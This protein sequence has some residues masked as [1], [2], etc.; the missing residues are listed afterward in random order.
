MNNGLRLQKIKYNII[1]ELNKQEFVKTPA[2]VILLF[3]QYIVLNCFFIS[4][5]PHK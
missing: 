4:I 1:Q 3:S 5:K 2:I